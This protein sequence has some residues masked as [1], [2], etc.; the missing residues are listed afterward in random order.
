MSAMVAMKPRGLKVKTETISLSATDHNSKT[1]AIPPAGA[2]LAESNS[3]TAATTE[4]G[5]SNADFRSFFQ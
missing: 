1:A 4:G 3:C 5:K 2:H